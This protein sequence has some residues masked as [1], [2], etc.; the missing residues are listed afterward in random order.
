MVGQDLGVSQWVEIDQEMINRYADLTGD[1]G[2]IHVDVAR[3][4]ETR[5]G[6]T[7]A[8]GLLVL[9]MTG[10]AA[11]DVLPEISD[12]TFLMNYGYEKIRMTSPV[13]T[14]SRIRVRFAV[15]GTE[16]RRANEGMVR[17]LVTVECDRSDRPALVAESLLLV[18]LKS[19]SH[20]S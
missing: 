5:F 12:R 19:Q 16:M 9:A 3:A 10:G 6:G 11:K 17:F 13:P 15:L 14:G 18:V 1:D 4:R 8:H 2:F 7:I 20:S